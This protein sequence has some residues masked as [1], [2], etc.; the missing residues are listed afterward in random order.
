[1]KLTDSEQRFVQTNSV[2]YSQGP[3][4]QVYDFQVGL[5]QIK[6]K[7]AQQPKNVNIMQLK[8]VLRE[9]MAEQN[10]GAISLRTLMD[11]YPAHHSE[12]VSK[13]SDDVSKAYQFVALL[14]LANE[15]GLDLNNDSNGDIIIQK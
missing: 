12:K 3:E 9:E 8:N 2:F 5:K 11:E 4:S 6:I 10:S 1:M 13:S 7:F 15:D 14:H